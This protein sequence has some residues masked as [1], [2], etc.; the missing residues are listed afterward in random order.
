MLFTHIVLVV[1]EVC[2]RDPR[3]L[4]ERPVVA[5]LA[6]APDAGEQTLSIPIVG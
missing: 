1:S 2:A 5:A 6:R 3:A 4:H